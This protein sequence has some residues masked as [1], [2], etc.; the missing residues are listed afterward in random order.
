MS[1]LFIV[2]KSKTLASRRLPRTITSESFTAQ[3]LTC[4]S[5]KSFFSSCYKKRPKTDFTFYNL[6]KIFKCLT[7]KSFQFILWVNY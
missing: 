7:K 2:S 4:E 1:T 6:G 3:N 5:A